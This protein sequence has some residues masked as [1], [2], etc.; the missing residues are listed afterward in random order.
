[1]KN[2]FSP[3]DY[4]MLVLLATVFGSNFVMPKI[5]LQALPPVLSTSTDVWA[6]TVYTGLMA[7]AFGTAFSILF[8]GEFL[9]ANDA[10]ALLIILVGVALSR[11]RPKR[12]IISINKGV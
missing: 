9:P 11:R 6:A 7:T 4:F 10:I 3:S 2:K 1:M 8:L 12:E 5:S